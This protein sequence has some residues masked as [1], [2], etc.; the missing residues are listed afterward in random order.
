[1]RAATAVLIV[2]LYTSAGEGSPATSGLGQKTLQVA[3]GIFTSPSFSYGYPL[4]LSAFKNLKESFRPTEFNEPTD[5]TKVRHMLES[6][7]V[8]TLK[9]HC[10]QHCVVSPWI[11]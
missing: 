1:M 9:N 6:L 2:L 10:D 8:Q 11:F 3:L 7:L 5:V 4:V